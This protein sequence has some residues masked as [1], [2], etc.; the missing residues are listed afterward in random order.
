MV[1]MFL[2]FYTYILQ[3]IPD[4]TVPV[5]AF[6]KGSALFQ[7]VY[8]FLDD[9]FILYAFSHFLKKVLLYLTKKTL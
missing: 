7:P 5:T 8:F 9:T 1:P 6:L 2:Y 3:D 4:D